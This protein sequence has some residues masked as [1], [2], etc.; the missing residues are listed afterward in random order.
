MAS[1]GLFPK[2]VNS[3]FYSEWLKGFFQ[4]GPTVVKFHLINS[5]LREKQFCAETLIGKNQGAI[6]SLSTA[7]RGP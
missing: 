5:K 2:G 6:A 1:E 7:F 3:G 4:V